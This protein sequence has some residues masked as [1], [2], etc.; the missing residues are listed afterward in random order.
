MTKIP[1]PYYKAECIDMIYY[2]FIE[3]VDSSN[4][5]SYILL[6]GIS[7]TFIN[8]YWILKT[9]KIGRFIDDFH[10]GEFIKIEYD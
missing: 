8:G 9:V 5:K 10:F 6:N 2:M 4:R 7:Y 3:P 1:N